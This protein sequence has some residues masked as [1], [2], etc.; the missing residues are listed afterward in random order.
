MC[1]NAILCA[2]TKSIGLTEGVTAVKHELAMSLKQHDKMSRQLNQL[3]ELVKTLVIQIHGSEVMMSI[4]CVE[5]V[6]F[7]AF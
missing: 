5:L 4:L 6:T 7:V 2:A 3:M 1:R